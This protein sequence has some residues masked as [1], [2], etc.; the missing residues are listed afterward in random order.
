MLPDIYPTA[1]KKVTWEFNDQLGIFAKWN[2]HCETIKD[3][4]YF[5]R[6]A[7]KNYVQQRYI[8]IGEVMPPQ[9]FKLLVYIS[10]TVT[11]KFD[12]DEDVFKIMPKKIK[13]DD[14]FKQKFNKDEWEKLCKDACI[15]T[16]DGEKFLKDCL[17]YLPKFYND[18]L[19]KFN[20]N[21]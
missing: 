10:E 7:L 18:I 20:K 19:I 4:P 5:V 8:G 11:V 14:K 3:N 6:N 2:S 13:V 16:K 9:V 15:T 1:L 12:R 17:K 21:N